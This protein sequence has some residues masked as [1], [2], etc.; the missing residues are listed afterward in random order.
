MWVDEAAIRWGLDARH[1]GAYGLDLGDN[2]WASGLSRILLGVAMA[3]DGASSIPVLP[4]DDVSSADIDLAGRFGEY[5]DRLRR[6][7]EAAGSASTI[8][9]WVSA[10]SVA[11]DQLTDTSVREAWL[12]AQFDRELAMIVDSSEAGTTTSDATPLLLADVRQLLAHRLGGRPTRANFRTGTLTVCTM[13]PMRS[14]P[15]RVVCLL[16]LDDGVFPR[17]GSVDGDDVLARRPLTGERDVRSEDRQLFLDAILA[18]QETLVIT[19]TGA[20]EHT[21]ADR[22]PAVP[23]GELLSADRHVARRSH[24]GVTAGCAT[25]SWSG[26]RCSRS[27]RAT[28]CRGRWCPAHRSAST[29]PRGQ[30][31]RRCAAPAGHHDPGPDAAPRGGAGRRRAGRPEG[32]RGASGACLPAPAAR[33]DRTAGGRGDARRHPDHPRRAQQVDVR[34]PDAARHPG[35]HQ[36][37]RRG[38]RRAAPRRA[39]TRCPRRPGAQRGRRRAAAR[40]CWARCGSGTLRT[41]ATRPGRPCSAPSTSTSTSATADG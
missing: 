30:E 13:V 32:V 20:N 24:R 3:E 15:H 23:L 22:P 28:C 11:V 18:A 25:A 29:G 6:F 4:V 36:P 2:T 37:L 12:R 33:R 39:A 35:R 27:T 7:V 9:S 17:A 16:G 5:V 14:V 41:A 34:G 10:L 31:P 38:A 1:R 26:T 21:G 8:G 19:Y 40:S